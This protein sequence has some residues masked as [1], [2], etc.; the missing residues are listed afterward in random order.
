M[1]V[2]IV[3]IT[4]CDALP[5]PLVPDT[6][7]CV[8]RVDDLFDVHFVN[9]DASLIRRLITKEDIVALISQM[10]ISS[11]LYKGTWNAATNT[12][13]L[14]SGVGTNG[15]FYRVNVA[16]STAIDGISSWNIGD[17]IIFD[18]NHWDKIE[19]GSTPISLSV[20]EW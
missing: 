14:V 6:I 2:P 13:T 4:R 20:A 10:T 1:T 19:L 12:P 11:T 7:Y 9:E 15:D 18:G 8:K 3:Y 5:D 17:T 16:G